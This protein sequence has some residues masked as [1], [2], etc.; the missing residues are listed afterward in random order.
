MA[1]DAVPADKSAALPPREAEEAA[2][3]GTPVRPEA[4]SGAMPPEPLTRAAAPRDE[5]QV[6]VASPEPGELPGIRREGTAVAWRVLEGLAAALGF[7]F[8]AGLVMR[9]K[10]SRRNDRT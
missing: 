10:F 3:L 2:A 9:V 4:E 7:V 1:G 5:E 6:P 8:L